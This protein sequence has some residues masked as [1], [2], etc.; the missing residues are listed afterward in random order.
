ML[1]EGF[2]AGVPALKYHAIDAVS[3]SKLSRFKQ[4]PAAVKVPFEETKAMRLGT[5][6]HDLFLEPDSFVE[7]WLVLPYDTRRT[8]AAEQLIKLEGT[9]LGRGD[10]TI[11]EY[12]D[13]SGMVTSLRQN[14]DAIDLLRNAVAIEE[15]AIWTDGATKC[16]CKSRKD[17]AGNGWLA[18]LKTTKDIHKFPYTALDYGYF[19]QAAWYMRGD[20]MLSRQAGKFMFI[21][22]ASSEPY[23]TQV[24]TVG[25]LTL[26]AAEQELDRLFSNY[27]VAQELDEW[28][29]ALPLDVIDAPKWYINKAFELDLDEVKS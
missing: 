12:K 20:K 10:L 9:K 13:V 4:S 25:S 5:A 6:T 7:R 3:N 29:S 21:V 24:L 27:Q 28:P 22:V 1:K 8:R 16:L 23:E 2:H 14:P 19:R 11:T 15:T 18:D 26:Q 17:L